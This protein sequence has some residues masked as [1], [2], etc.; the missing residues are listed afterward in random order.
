M[1]SKIPYSNDGALTKLDSVTLIC[2]SRW[3]HITT[4]TF[5]ISPLSSV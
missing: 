5:S 2:R 1:Q 3:H 4:N